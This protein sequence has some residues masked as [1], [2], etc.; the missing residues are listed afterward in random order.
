M[1]DVQL[2]LGSNSSVFSHQLGHGGK[3]LLSEVWF[4][5]CKDGG[6]SNFLTKW[7]GFNER[8]KRS[9]MVILLTHNRVAKIWSWPLGIKTENVCSFS[10]SRCTVYEKSSQ[11]LLREQMVSQAPSLPLPASLTSNALLSRAR[12]RPHLPWASRGKRKE[13]LS[14]QYQQHLQMG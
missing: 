1:N 10:P 4:S 6:T 9:M 14:P 7:W 13:L 2:D 11:A 3:A 8:R 5:Y 12:G